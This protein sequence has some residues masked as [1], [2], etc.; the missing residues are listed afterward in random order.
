M[1]RI[2]RYKKLAKDRRLMSVDIVYPIPVLKCLVN[3]ICT[4]IGAH[5]ANDKGLS[6]CRESTTM[7]Q[8][9]KLCECEVA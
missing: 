3:S 8:L 7:A 5:T 2:A 4:A 1:Q 6:N 9:G